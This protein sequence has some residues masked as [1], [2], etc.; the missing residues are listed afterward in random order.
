MSLLAFLIASHWTRLIYIQTQTHRPSSSFIYCYTSTKYQSPSQL[1]IL[2]LIFVYHFSF[3]CLHSFIGPFW[4][5]SI[6]VHSSLFRLFLV[7]SSS[8]LYY[9]STDYTHSLRL[10]LDSSSLS[11]Q[12]GSCLFSSRCSL[13]PFFLRIFSHV[14]VV[15]HTYR[16][17]IFL[18]ASL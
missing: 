8:L 3:W 10:P 12:S 17:N 18:I 1:H 7:C 4:I 15:V 14:E 11:H 5:S 6:C 16:A 9:I 2:T 13:P